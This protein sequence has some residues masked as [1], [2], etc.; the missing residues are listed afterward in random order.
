MGPIAHLPV[1]L[2]VAV[3]E[4]GVIGR[5]NGLPWDLPDDLQHFKS[6]TMGRP[7]VMGRKTF[8]SIGRP[9][10]GRTNIVLTRDAGWQAPGV[11]TVHDF[12]AAI[13]RGEDQAMLDGADALMVIGGSEVYQL[14]FPY[15]ERVILTAVHAEVQGDAFFDLEQLSDWVE[16][17]R[18]EY[19]AGT[20][21]SHD[22]AVVDLC[23]PE[24]A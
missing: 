2:V 21:N 9:L 23:R 17:S 16:L 18:A 4:N 3:A 8:E 20:R 12:P 7:I 19:A 14:A 22:F 24:A 6:A 15:A 11:D 10:P 1:V 13:Q 5:G